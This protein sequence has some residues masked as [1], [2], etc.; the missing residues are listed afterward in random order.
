VITQLYCPF[1]LFIIISIKSTYMVEQAPF[2]DNAGAAFYGFMGVS[3]ALVL[4]STLKLSQTSAQ[5]TVQ[6]RQAQA[7]AAYPSGDPESS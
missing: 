5:P 6:P 7:S 1:L 3:M 4:A 2:P